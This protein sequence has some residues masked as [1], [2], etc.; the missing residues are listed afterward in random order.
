MKKT[1]FSFKKFNVQINWI[2]WN[3][4]ERAGKSIGGFSGSLYDGGAWYIVFLFCIKNERDQSYQK[5]QNPPQFPNSPQT[6]FIH[7]LISFLIF[8]LLIFI[9]YI[10]VLTISL[11][12]VS[13]SVAI[14]TAR[15]QKAACELRK[16]VFHLFFLPDFLSM[17]LWGM[18]HRF[19]LDINKNLYKYNFLQI[20][21]N[22]L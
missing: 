2:M 9:S 5:S 22:L 4:R 6:F 17:K 12:C 16:L 11:R 7:F 8:C 13:I 21:I 15:S 3:G 20:R 10:K 1:G 14:W 18:K 19:I